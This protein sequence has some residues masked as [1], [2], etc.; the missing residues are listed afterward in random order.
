MESL[1]FVCVCLLA[2]VVVVEV[3][4]SRRIGIWSIGTNFFFKKNSF[5]FKNEHFYTTIKNPYWGRTDFN[6]FLVMTRST[7]IY[8]SLK[9]E[10]SMQNREER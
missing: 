4:S 5:C 6:F 2:V 9:S 3:Y 1:I 8:W 7:Y 10:F